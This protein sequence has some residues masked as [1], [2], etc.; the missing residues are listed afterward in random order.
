M[1]PGRNNQF[2]AHWGNCMH[3]IAVFLWYR[4]ECRKLQGRHIGYPRF[5][6]D[7]GFA[8]SKI[9]TKLRRRIL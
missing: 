1:L 5:S 3:H 6:G 9:Y 8:W 4:H 7:N 2:V